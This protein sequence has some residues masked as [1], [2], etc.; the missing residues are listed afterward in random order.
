[1]L[2]VQVRL[3][4]TK[5]ANT[6]EESLKNS[7]KLNAA[8][9]TT[10]WH[11]DKDGFL[12]HSPSE[13]SLYYKGPTLQKIIL[14]FLGPPPHVIIT[15]EVCVY[16]IFTLLFLILTWGF[17]F[18]DFRERGRGGRERQREKH[19]LV[20][21]SHICPQLGTKPATLG[22]VPRL[23]VKSMTVWCTGWCSDQLNYPSK[24]FCV[25]F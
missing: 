17:V 18:I 6:L 22:Y 2:C 7:P 24:V 4:L 9:H 12:K 23:G 21:D 10:S 19:W 20:A 14:C 5:W 13:G 15:G 11:T 16:F 8:S 1:M 3:P 25:Y